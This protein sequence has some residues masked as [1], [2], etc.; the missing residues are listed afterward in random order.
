[1]AYLVSTQD[2]DVIH[3]TTH[4]IMSRGDLEYLRERVDMAVRSASGVAAR[5]LNAAR[6]SL[7]RFD[8]SRLRDSVESMRD[9]FGRRWDEDRVTPLLDIS[10]QQ[11]AKPTM[12]GYIMAEPRTRRLYYQGRLDG[13][14]GLY[15]DD[16][17][18]AVGRRHYRYREVMN[19]S[20]VEEV[21]D[22]DRFVTYPEVMSEHG[23]AELT[24]T[25]K[26]AV[27]RTWAE[28]V[29]YLERGK[30]DPTSPLRKTL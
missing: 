29:E 26:D 21:E 12:R 1:M 30:Q 19:G 13:Y 4:G 17:V 22:E 2:D 24:K 8:F 23:D 15:E 10:S 18:G 7:A 5:Y 16:D 6:D 3:A 27:R 11:Q 20:Y 9:R 14:S 28:Q 25:G